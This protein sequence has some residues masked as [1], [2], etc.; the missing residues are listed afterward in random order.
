[1]L[2][3][4]TTGT[5]LWYDAVLDWGLN[6]GPPALEASTLPLGYRVAVLITIEL[7]TVAVY[8]FRICM[9]VDK[10]VPNYFKGDNKQ[11]GM[12]V[13]FRDL[14]HNSSFFIEL[15]HCS[16]NKMLTK[17]IKNNDLS[18]YMYR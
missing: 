1:M 6:P 14:T 10:P 3:K 12:G 2:N 16:T 15:L 13:S 8:D 9:K 7:N 4:G 17:Y 5:I 11:C 18:K